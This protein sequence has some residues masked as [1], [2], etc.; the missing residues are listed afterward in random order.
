[1]RTI[2]QFANAPM[3]NTQQRYRIMGDNSGHKYFIPVEQEGM[4]EAWVKC[5]G[6]ENY[7]DRGYRG[8]DFNA[9]RIDGRF[10]FTDPKNE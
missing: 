1:M 5:N 8:P 2:T 3:S 4:F 10:T 9:N 7:A 6:E